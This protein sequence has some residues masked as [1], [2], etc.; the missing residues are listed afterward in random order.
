M[1]LA[2]KHFTLQIIGEAKARNEY[3][4]FCEEI[5]GQIQHTVRE[6]VVKKHYAAKIS[7]DV[8]SLI[9]AL[10]VHDSSLEVDYNYNEE[11]ERFVLHIYGMHGGVIEHLKKKFE[12][13]TE[14]KTVDLRDIFNDYD[15]G[16]IKREVWK[17]VEE[18]R[19]FEN[20]FVNR[21]ELTVIGLSDD[22][23]RIAGEIRNRLLSLGSFS[24]EFGQGNNNN[25]FAD[26]SCAVTQLA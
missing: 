14:F 20:A 21:F 10:R 5:I 2:G 7:R 19:R 16:V 4:K 24:N 15:E 13:I 18:R 8:A 26:L 22:V 9:E 11:T 3:F 23:D 6:R 25:N 1:E 17:L 12:K